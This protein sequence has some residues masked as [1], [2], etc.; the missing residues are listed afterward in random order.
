MFLSLV[1]QPLQL[2]NDFYIGSRIYFNRHLLIINVSKS[3]K[4][5]IV[6]VVLD[7]WF[8]LKNLLKNKL[9]YY[10]KTKFMD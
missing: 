6:Y 2:F 5:N 9:S 7:T 3:G 8:Q 10:T 1:V 4:V